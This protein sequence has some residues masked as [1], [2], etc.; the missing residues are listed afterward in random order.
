MK[1]EARTIVPFFDGFYNSLFEDYWDYK[2]EVGDAFTVNINEKIKEVLPSFSYV[3]ETIHSPKYYNYETDEIYATATFESKELFMYLI[4]N[5]E[6][7]EEYCKNNFSSYDGFISF[8]PNNSNEF[9]EK[10][11]MASDEE[12]SSFI[13]GAIGFALENTF[14]ENISNDLNE[15]TYYDIAENYPVDDDFNDDE[16]DE[17]H[18][19]AEH[20]AEWMEKHPNGYYNSEK[21]YGDGDIFDKAYEEAYTV[22]N[23]AGS[24]EDD[25]YKVC[26]DVAENYGVDADKL[27]NKIKEEEKSNNQWIDEAKDDTGDFT[28]VIY[29]QNM[30]TMVLTSL[31]KNEPV[32]DKADDKNVEPLYL[33]VDEAEKIADDEQ[34]TADKGIA[35]K[36]YSKSFGS[37]TM[38]RAEFNLNFRNEQIEESFDYMAT[39]KK[40]QFQLL[41]RMKQDCEY[42][43]NGH[44]DANHLWAGS[45]DE[46]I[47]AM[48][49]LQKMLKPE[50]L[51]SEDIDRYEEQMKDSTLTEDLD[52]KFDRLSELNKK[53]TY[54]VADVDD[55]FVQGGFESEK[56]AQNWIYDYCNR[57][58]ITPEDFVVYPE[59][60]QEDGSKPYSDD[61]LQ[62]LTDLNEATDKFGYGGNKRDS[63]QDRYDYPTGTD[64]WGVKRIDDNGSGDIYEIQYNGGPGHIEILCKGRNNKYYW[65]N[66]HNVSDDVKFRSSDYELIKSLCKKYGGEPVPLKT[67]TNRIDESSKETFTSPL[68]DTDKEVEAT[69]ENKPSKEFKKKL[70]K[71]GKLKGDGTDKLEE[72][73]E[74]LNYQMDIDIW[75]RYTGAYGTPVD[76]EV[77]S[78]EEGPWKIC[79]DTL[80]CDPG[81]T[82]EELEQYILD[83]CED[84]AR[85]YVDNVPLK[86]NITRFYKG[87]KRDEET[88]MLNETKLEESEYA[89]VDTNPFGLVR[90]GDGCFAL[91]R[92]LPDGRIER[93]GLFDPDE[94]E[95]ALKRLAEV[96][97]EKLN[98][99]VDSE[100]NQD[101]L[102]EL[103]DT[104]T[105][106]MGDDF[107]SDYDE[108]DYD[109]IVDAVDDFGREIDG[110]DSSNLN[111]RLAYAHALKEKWK[112]EHKNMKNL[113]ED[114]YSKPSEDEVD[115]KLKDDPSVQEMV[116]AILDN[117]DNYND[118]EKATLKQAIFNASHGEPDMLKELYRK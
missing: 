45:V 51:S 87:D 79:K 95:E 7:F 12:A 44:R 16:E 3:Y 30:D 102:Q 93:A 92:K 19:D 72:T 46:Q 52:D 11:K 64:Y 15:A 47:K 43:I 76:A 4:E 53:P 96:N 25:L 77:Y 36:Y 13:L 14:G 33:T 89:N 90:Q 109:S 65:A 94:K 66:I 9:V 115:P 75:Y 17:D 21:D 22:W 103:Y 91:Q 116:K 18:Y 27:Y 59:E 32:W 58:A 118:G 98:E 63:W 88:F 74:E 24:V 110:Y 80:F 113:D 23:N 62:R 105:E 55:E 56:E 84:E 108:T 8:L 81:S 71:H 40:M 104:I 61:K 41:D 82:N 86:V 1:C 114:R 28:V 37:Q 60:E 49:E 6:K 5:E 2:D 111:T 106:A 97:G 67:L 68:A 31:D 39:D 57:N 85:K 50:W 99:S 117:W 48:R 35:N 101:V 34:K 78:E 100:I 69:A 112:N 20:A 83:R 54:Y 70:E 42:Y 38:S 26:S 107:L 29:G 10:F 73:P